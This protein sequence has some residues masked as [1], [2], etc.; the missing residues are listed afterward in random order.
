MKGS[1]PFI[2]YCV[3]KDAVRRI[4]LMDIW[5][6]TLANEIS[7]ISVA[8][9]FYTNP[10]CTHTLGESIPSNGAMPYVGSDLLR[11]E[12]LTLRC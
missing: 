2:V 7:V 10:T 9:I 8:S 1:I 6:D 3:E 4:I 11:K 5:Q 12:P